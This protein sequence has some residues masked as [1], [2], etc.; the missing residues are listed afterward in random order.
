MAS[1]QENALQSLK[2]DVNSLKRLKDIKFALD[3]S[4]IVNVTDKNGTIISVNDKLCEISGYRRE[5]LIGKNHRM[6]NSGYHPRQFFTNLWKTILKGDIWRGEICN[7]TKDGEIF[8]VDT[9][10]V[11]FLNENNEPYQF[12]SVR[13]DI[14]KRKQ[15]EQKLLQSEQMYR[16]ISENTSDLIAIID[17][18]ANFQYA[19]PSHEEVLHTKLND[20]HL[21]RLYDWIHED[22]RAK[23]KQQIATLLNDK[24]HAGTI[25]YR[26]LS[27]ERSYIYVH[28]TVNVIYKE[29]SEVLCIVLIT[30]DI[31]DRKRTEQTYAHFATHDALTDVPNRGHFLQL[32]DEE[33]AR[34]KRK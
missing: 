26:I 19:S 17:Q 28:S 5:E 2:A 24:K 32:L 18:E 9:T 25:E 29:N 30:R 33:V 6:L 16:L 14:T 11:P 10:I 8:W 23:V 1:Q 20:I 22:D 34:A 4:T 27:S 15:M 3:Q 12:I 7:L 21:S 13:H 31:T